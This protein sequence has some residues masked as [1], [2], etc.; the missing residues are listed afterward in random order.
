[1]DRA[2][3]ELD[4]SWKAGSIAQPP[5]PSRRSQALQPRLGPNDSQME[6]W[7]LGSIAEGGGGAVQGVNRLE[8]S[9]ATPPPARSVEEVSRLEAGV[10]AMTF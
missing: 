3:S 7:G 1:V 5:S 6:P 4:A 10:K 8:G 9:G 2:I